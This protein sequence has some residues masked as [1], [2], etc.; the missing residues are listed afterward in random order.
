MVN[1]NKLKRGAADLELDYDSVIKTI[2]TM[3]E[4]QGIFASKFSSFEVNAIS[5]S[6]LSLLSS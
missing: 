1:L 2:Q 3:I 6:V 4:E 5:Y